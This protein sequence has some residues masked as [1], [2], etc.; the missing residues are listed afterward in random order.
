MVY[1]AEVYAHVRSA[2][3]SKLPVLTY[4]QLPST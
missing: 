3:T 1:L 2:A 4:L